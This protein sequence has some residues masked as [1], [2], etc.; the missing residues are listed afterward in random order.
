MYHGILIALVIYTGLIITLAVNADSIF[1]VI[2][3]ERIKLVVVTLKPSLF[4]VGLT[5]KYN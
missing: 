5:N 4:T 3:N 1:L 2:V